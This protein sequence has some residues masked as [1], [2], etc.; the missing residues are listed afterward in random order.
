MLF[1]HAATQTDFNYGGVRC[2]Q[3]TYSPA[4]FGTLTGNTWRNTARLGGRWTS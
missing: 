1:L 3:V 4:R 2:Q